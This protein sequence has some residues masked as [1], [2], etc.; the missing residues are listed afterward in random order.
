MMGVRLG[1]ADAYRRVRPALEPLLGVVGA[2]NLHKVVSLVRIYAPC[3]ALMNGAVAADPPGIGTANP[4]HDRITSTHLRSEVT[5]P[6][7]LQ[8]LQP[9]MATIMTL[10]CR[11]GYLA[12]ALEAELRAAGLSTGDDDDPDLQPE[13]ASAA[14]GLSGATAAHFARQA[15]VFVR[16]LENQPSSALSGMGDAPP[17]AI[18]LAVACKRLVEIKQ[19][20][21]TSAG[22][23]QDIVKE[24]VASSLVRDYE[25]EPWFEDADWVEKDSKGAAPTLG[26]SHLLNPQVMTIYPALLASMRLDPS[27]SGDPQLLQMVV[28]GLGGTPE[29]V[30]QYMEEDVERLLN[31]IIGTPQTELLTTLRSVRDQIREQQGTIQAITAALGKCDGKVQRLGINSL[32]SKPPPEDQAALEEGV[33]RTLHA[34]VESFCRQGAGPA[35]AALSALLR[36]SNMERVLREL[37]TSGRA[38]AEKARLWNELMVCHLQSICAAWYCCESYLAQWQA[39]HILA[40]YL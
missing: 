40:D 19:Q 30:R 9:S 24:Q 12:K 10:T 14:S 32:D 29:R 31:V 35:H 34:H 13:E 3:K 27:Y 16:Y 21:A 26:L 11:G 23:V 7:V 4:E 33:L 39:E 17:R 28:E 37:A 20:D 22:C 6:L 2:A 8:G 18:T 36:S 25:Y 15:P 1:F 5:Q 38:E